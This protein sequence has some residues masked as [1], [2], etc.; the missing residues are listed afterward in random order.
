MN[1]AILL[2][3][4]NGTRMQSILKPKQFQNINGLPL[5]AYSLLTFHTHPLIDA[6]VIVTQKSH[7]KRLSMWVEAHHLN[8]VKMIISGGTSR[9]ESVFLG[10]E[11]I[12]SWVK[13]DDIIIIHDAA[14]PFVTTDMI[15][16]HL[17]Q[18]RVHFAVNTIIPATDTILS[19]KDGKKMDAI[20][21]RHELYQVQTP[22]SFHY[23]TLFQAHQKAKEL[24][25]ENASDDI[26]L[27][28][29]L[30]IPVALVQGTQENFKVTY[31]IDFLVMKTI[32]KEKHRKQEDQIW[33][34]KS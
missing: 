24:Q 23:D 25:I 19:S 22:Q 16:H 1:I 4:G 30:H 10:L 34:T 14:R 12:A 29:L 7:Q 5:F 18:C 33:K 27:V 20:L 6:I 11:S 8:K 26:Q 21:N 2:A 3:A 32:L 9:Q 28:T 13:P 31:P 17:E 15:S